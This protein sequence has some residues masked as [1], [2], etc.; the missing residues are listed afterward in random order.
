MTKNKMIQKICEVEGK[1]SQVKVGDVR[2]LLK[3]I[4]VLCKDPSFSMALLKYI[5]LGR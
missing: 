3:A 1:K 2:E 4:K 5:F